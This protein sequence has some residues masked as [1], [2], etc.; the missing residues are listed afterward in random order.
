MTGLLLEKQA[1]VRLFRLIDFENPIDEGLLCQSYL[2]GHQRPS[3]FTWGNN[4]DYVGFISMTGGQKPTS[5]V[6]SRTFLSFIFI[7]L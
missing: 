5:F 7:I 1:T 2:I 6:I 3:D 4:L